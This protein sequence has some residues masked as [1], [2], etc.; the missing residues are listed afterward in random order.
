MRTTKPISTISFNTETYLKGKLDELVKAKKISAYHFIEHLPE[1]DEKKSHFHV[2]MLPSKMIQTDDIREE[3]KEYDPSNPSKP[4]GCLP[5]E[6]SNFDNWYLYSLHDE[7]YLSSKG[8]SR[9]YHYR[10]DLVVSSDDDFLDEQ[11]KKIDLLKLSPYQD[12][13]DAQESGL[14]WQEYFR[15]G[16]VPLAQINQF[17]TAWFTL[18]NVNVYRGNYSPHG[19]EAYHPFETVYVNENTG[20]VLKS[21]DA[22]EYTVVSND[23]DLPFE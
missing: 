12:M 20:E 21:P 3:F 18:Q 2:W 10:R 9:K 16:T 6:S 1:E 4:L 19:N 5:F 13:I 15:R 8:Q 7:R 14:S 22:D 23:L 17:Q 11:I